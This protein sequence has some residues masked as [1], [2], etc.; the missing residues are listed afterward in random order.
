MIPR[1]KNF[2]IIVFGF[3]SLISMFPTIFNPF[4]YDIFYIFFFLCPLLLLAVA[5]IPVFRRH[6]KTWVCVICALDIAYLIFANPELSITLSL[7][8]F[9]ACIVLTLWPNRTDKSDTAQTEAVSKK[10]TSCPTCGS[11]LWADGRCP[12][13][14]NRMV[15]LNWMQ[16]TGQLPSKPQRHRQ[17]SLGSDSL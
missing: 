6:R 1:H 17:N 5:C 7:I 10:A 2:L 14:Y 13:C 12:E 3:L 15:L 11:E 8:I 4:G 16:E 9:A